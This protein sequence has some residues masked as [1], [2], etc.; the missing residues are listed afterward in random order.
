[1]TRRSVEALVAA[2]VAAVP[3]VLAVPAKA[4]APPVTEGRVTPAA[5]KFIDRQTRFGAMPTYTTPDSPD[6]RD[7]DKR[8]TAYGEMWDQNATL[9]EAAAVPVQGRANIENSIRT[10][11]GLVPSLN[12]RPTRIA[13]DRNVVMYG[14]DNQAVLNKNK[15]E[16]PAIYRV[17]LNKRGDVVQG[18]RYYDRFRWFKPLDGTLKDLFADVTDRRRGAAPP[19]KGSAR[20]DDIPGRGAAWN[21][22]DAAALVDSTGDAALSGTGLD[23]RQL[24]TRAAKLAYLQRLFGTFGNDPDAKLDPGQRVRTP[25]ATYQEWFGTVNSQNR[26]T[27][28][29]IIERFGYRDGRLTDWTLTFDT[30]PLIADDQEIR[31]LYGLIQPSQ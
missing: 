20:P 19:A 1:M 15:V 18:R 29:G 27:S 6:E 13:A 4:D 12:F 7:L 9:W 5:Q 8:V 28:F 11:L 22:R 2:A 23:G 10:S 24:R 25:T 14:A 30:L 21:R 16:Y 17:V 26:T 31:R 3:V